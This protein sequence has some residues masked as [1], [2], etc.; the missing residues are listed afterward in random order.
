M[1][2]FFPKNVQN[3]R[4]STLF[5]AINKKMIQICV[6]AAVSYHKFPNSQFL[7]VCLF[8]LDLLFKKQNWEHCLWFK[9]CD[10]LSLLMLSTSQLMHS[11]A[12]QSRAEQSEW[13]KPSAV[14]PSIGAPAASL[15]ERQKTTTTTLSWGDPEKSS[16]KVLVQ[17]K[18]RVGLLYIIDKWWVNNIKYI[19]NAEVII[20]T[21]KK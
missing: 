12:P 9:I 15:T 19:Y 1:C 18:H 21:F 4:Q 7:F 13:L 8:F 10:Y 16:S 6:I 3:D 17:K 14:M 11:T 20:W 2:N 5:F